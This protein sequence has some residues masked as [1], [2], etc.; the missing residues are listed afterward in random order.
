[1]EVWQTR[2]Q[3]ELQPLGGHLFFSTIQPTPV[4]RGRKT[5]RS[6]SIKMTETVYGSSL[7]AVLTAGINALTIKPNVCSGQLRDA[8]AR[9]LALLALL[10]PA[11]RIRRLPPH[12][13]P[14]TVPS[15]DIVDSD[16]L[17]NAVLLVGRKVDAGL[18]FELQLR[19]L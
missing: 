16:V 3:A 14:T 11:K 6:H 17:C 13:D 7:S 2:P 19:A 12:L 10:L 1:M 9:N 8:Q 18:G 4:Y 5:L 15:L